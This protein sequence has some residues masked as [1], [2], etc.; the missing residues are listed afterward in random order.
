MLRS[1]S[2]SGLRA[3]PH[4]ILGP[5][6]PPLG[7]RKFFFSRQNVR[8]VIVRLRAE[9]DRNR[10]ENGFLIFFLRLF[11]DFFT[12]LIGIKCLPGND[13]LPKYRFFLNFVRT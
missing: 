6:T 3:P 2:I 9:A 7:G 11:D 12:Q 13:K 4:F 1:N 5:I 8:V 10:L